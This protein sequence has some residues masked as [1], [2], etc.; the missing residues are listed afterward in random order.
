M[1]SRDSRESKKS[2]EELKMDS[3]TYKEL[4]AKIL[5]YKKMGM[6]T[7]ILEIALDEKAEN[8]EALFRD[9][10][11]KAEEI[12]GLKVRLFHLRND[13]NE[14]M[15]SAI[16]SKMS[17]IDNY[18]HILESVSRLEETLDPDNPEN[19]RSKLIVK[20]SSLSDTGYDVTG[21][22]ALKEGD[23][24]EFALAVHAFEDGIAEME[25]LRKRLDALT[26][27]S[28]REDIVGIL[29]LMRDPTKV[30]EINKRISSIEDLVNHGEEFFSKKIETLKNKGYDVTAFDGFVFTDFDLAYDKIRGFEKKVERYEE[31]RES[32]K[33]INCSSLAPVIEELVRKLDSFENLP[34]IEK[35]FGQ[36]EG[37]IKSRR[38]PL[39]E[40]LGAFKGEGFDISELMA[41]HILNFDGFSDS[42]EAFEK[43][44][45]EM[46]TVVTEFK[47]IDNKWF[48]KE[49]SAISG[50]MRNPFKTAESRQAIEDLRLA[51]DARVRE[52]HGEA[53]NWKAQGLDVSYLEEAEGL[54]LKDA[55]EVYETAKEDIKLLEEARFRLA[56]LDRGTF[57]K[58]IRELEESLSQPRNVH[59]AF[60]R[61]EEL[62]GSLQKKREDITSKV[63]E[64]KGRGYSVARMEPLLEKRID[65]L[66]QEWNR[67]E[68]DVESLMTIERGLADLDTP[69]LA[70]KV[71]EVRFHLK[72]PDKRTEAE[73]AFAVLEEA[74]AAVRDRL[75]SR[76][77][78][79]TRRG[80]VTLPLQ[81]ILKGDLTELSTAVENFEKLIEKT[82]PLKEKLD[83]LD[84]SLFT[85]RSDEIREKLSDP[86]KIEEAR[87]G[88]KILEDEIREEKKKIKNQI[89]ELS[90]SG[91][92]V[93]PLL[94]ETSSSLKNQRKL[95]EHFVSCIDRVRGLKAY[96][97]ELD[98]EVFP[99]E[100]VEIEALLVH[101]LRHE[102]AEMMIKELEKKVT[103][104]RADI[105]AQVSALAEKGYEV[106][107]ILP[108]LGARLALLQNRWDTFS[109]DITRLKK[110][111]GEL[112][113]LDC[114]IFQTEARQII[115][116]LKI[117]GRENKA[118][119]KIEVLRERIRAAKNKYA[120]MAAN[121]E[122]LG[123]S[124]RYLR[125]NM[126]RPLVKVAEI[127]EDFEERIE[128]ITLLE[129]EYRRLDRESFPDLC[130]RI[131][132]N[133]KDPMALERVDRDIEALKGRIAG[134]ASQFAEFVGALRE[135]GFEVSYLEGFL[136]KRISLQ[137]AAAGRFE[138]WKADL[139]E[140][141]TL[142][143]DLDS[144]LDYDEICRLMEMTLDVTKIEAVRERVENYRE[145]LSTE[146]NN[147]KERAMELW[148]S[149]FDISALTSAYSKP[150]AD[151]D[152]ILKTFEEE[153]VKLEPLVEK[154]NSLDCS[155]HLSDRKDISER[156]RKLESPESI[157]TLLEGL[158][159]KIE[160][161]RDDLRR[162]IARLQK[163][164]FDISF[165]KPVWSLPLDKAGD[166][167]QK[168]EDMASRA[169]KHIKDLE[170]LD[171]SL[172]PEDTQAILR[173]LKAP[174]LVFEAEEKIESVS[175]GVKEFM[176]VAA[177]RVAGIAKS[178]F[179]VDELKPLEGENC[180]DIGSRL[181]NAETRVAE[182][183]EIASRMEPLRC[184]ALTQDF[185]KFDALFWNPSK[186][187][188]TRKAAARIE[189]KHS[190]ASARWEAEV[191]KLEADG[192]CVSSLKGSADADLDT[193]LAVL[194]AY[195]MNA[196][197]CSELSRLLER[198]DTSVLPGAADQLKKMLKNPDNLKD[199]TRDFE[200]MKAEL[201]RLSKK[202]EGDIV[203]LES[204]GYDTESLVDRI[205]GIKLKETID[206]IEEVKGS[207]PA[208]ESMRRELL[209]MD[210]GPF[211]MEM[212]NIILRIDSLG[213]PSEI[214]EE[215]DKLKGL[216]E[217]KAQGFE[218]FIARQDKAGFDT[219][220]LAAARK[221]SLKRKADL[222]FDFEMT[223]PKARSL[224]ERLEL[225]DTSTLT[226]EAERIRKILKNPFNAEAASARLDLLESDISEA[227][228]KLRK[229]VDDLG[230]EGFMAG[231]IFES[232]PS[233]A[234][235]GAEVEKA[236]SEIGKAR[237]LILEM[238]GIDFSLFRAD[239]AEIRDLLTDPRKVQ[240][241]E[242][243]LQGVK[244]KIELKAQE[245]RKKCE[246]FITRG[247]ECQSLVA[248]LEK[249]P[250]S[251]MDA[252]IRAFEESLARIEALAVKLKTLDCSLNGRELEDLGRLLRNPAAYPQALETVEK[253]ETHIMAMRSNLSS[254]ISKAAAE[255]YAVDRT[256]AAL[257]KKNLRDATADMDIFQREMKELKALRDEFNALA[258][259]NLEGELKK[260]VALTWDPRNLP[261]IPGELKRVL[262]LADAM[263]ARLT[264]ERDGWSK[265]GLKTGSVDKAL[266]D[267]VP[268][269]ELERNF[270][271]FR[272]KVSR[273]DSL[274]EDL[275][276]TM[277]ISF[278]KDAMKVK[279]LL[280]D[281]DKWEDADKA[282]QGLKAKIK[283]TRHKALNEIT[284]F[285]SRGYFFDYLLEC[286]S[287]E[288][289]EI[290]S[291][292]SRAR[293]EIAH[294]EE[295][296]SKI[297][298]TIVH[299]SKSE[300]RELTKLFRNKGKIGEAL[301]K[302]DSLRNSIASRRE[303]VIKEIGY[304][305]TLGYQIPEPDEETI[306]APLRLES[307]ASGVRASIREIEILKQEL[308]GIGTDLAPETENRIIEMMKDIS[309]VEKVREEI[310]NCR[311]AIESER[312]SLKAELEAF[313][314]KGYDTSMIALDHR[315]TLSSHREAMELFRAKVAELES[316]GE[317]LDKIDAPGFDTI[318]D[319]IRNQLCDIRLIGQAKTS[320][321][322]LNSQIENEK[323][324][325]FA[326]A[327]DLEVRGYD[328]SPLNAVRS[329][330][331][332]KILSSFAD[333]RQSVARL[334]ALRKTLES[335]DEGVLEN[336]FTRLM[337]MT[338]KVTNI[339][340][341]ETGISILSGKLGELRTQARSRCQVFEKVG[342]DVARLTDVLGRN[343]GQFEKSF[344]DYSKRVIEADSLKRELEGKDAELFPDKKAS[345]LRIC[346]DPYAIPRARE[347]LG[348][349]DRAIND[350]RREVAD[351]IDGFRSKGYAIP[352][353]L[354]IVYDE[355]VPLSKV[356]SVH[357]DFVGMTEKLKN[358]YS[359]LEKLD[360]SLFM[361]EV[362]ELAQGFLDFAQIPKI[363]AKIEDLKSRIATRR[364]DLL[365]EVEYYR[366][367]GYRC[368]RF[369]A[370]E[371]MSLSDLVET[372]EFLKARLTPVKEK[373][374]RLSLYLRYEKEKQ[375]A[376]ALLDRLY[377]VD[378]IDTTLLEIDS[379]EKR[380]KG[381][382]IEAIENYRASGLPTGRLEASME[383]EPESIAKVFDDFEADVK[384]LE[385]ARD[386]LSSIDLSKYREE[387]TIIEGLLDN[388][389][390]ATKVR[391]L[392]G[393]IR[394]AEEDRRT[395]T[396]AILEEY[397]NSGY[398]LSSLGDIE[399]MGISELEESV[400]DIGKKIDELS[401]IAAEAQRVRSWQLPI[402]IDDISTFLKDPA[403]VDKARA[404]VDAACS[405]AAAWIVERLAGHR[406]A[407]FNVKFVERLVDG[408]LKT[409]VEAFRMFSTDILTL[410]GLEKELL[411]FQ[412]FKSR[413]EYILAAAELKNPAA[414]DFIREKIDALKEARSALEAEKTKQK[415]QEIE[416]KAQEAKA[417]AEKAAAE[418]AARKAEEEEAAKK[419]AG[420]QAVAVAAAA[421]PVEG[422]AS[423]KPE[424]AAAAP[425]AGEAAAP[426]EAPKK[427]LP[428]K[429]P[430]M[431]DE[432]KRKFE[433]WK[434]RERGD[435]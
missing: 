266:S 82:R 387:A 291:R 257:L 359:S 276:R 161:D 22:E 99:A 236:V 432:M 2:L 144:S 228:S 399:G 244:K 129:S 130:S 141:K 316:I 3:N 375:E 150:L 201:A 422:K 350:K 226:D 191:A 435:S 239:E 427:P 232:K 235:A 247:Y 346:K 101:P 134:E 297:S 180:A 286:P 148:E 289:E 105:E 255:G 364:T 290:L 71:E 87:E 417:A 245:F 431:T 162:R 259:G 426:A 95:M 339:S 214:K 230:R 157:T 342:Y 149:G 430:A 59:D 332:T 338:W 142:I 340:E 324:N 293:K 70:G 433:E 143:F 215:I 122:A 265:R 380:A 274:R 275:T 135:E 365:K 343:L 279:I 194:T 17:S 165:T 410:A 196:A 329:L 97:S 52:Y 217:T 238:S 317:T 30:G 348:E 147:R 355:S 118:Q 29:A 13:S 327:M 107:E 309:L 205:A 115:G 225:M 198:T 212:K 193:K 174:E 65:L 159:R 311:R 381:H 187:E 305:R 189:K 46:R 233:L 397:R 169:A 40:K 292:V 54:P 25:S 323:T 91:Y 173:L 32:A 171:T 202:I 199:C 356:V 9:F 96:M 109:E 363:E 175:N 67:F 310:S 301:S 113:R 7:R 102:R 45:S 19:I 296:A 123:Y 271:L 220:E 206:L 92:S 154:L 222:M 62:Q 263:R 77:K 396:L 347:A 158:E 106:S 176:A 136:D 253:L 183:K 249:L 151:F 362:A 227:W 392:V 278:A 181:E 20:V 283:T 240:P 133:L 318:K 160:A 15:V 314:E 379:F 273:I 254:G 319:A 36:I 221:A 420:A 64:L 128:K 416:R 126:D 403:Q 48:P 108:F 73:N 391:R 386:M 306:L 21:L 18:D 53:I 203:F 98:S 270:E 38:K 163:K 204:Q 388:P 424:G 408:T 300:G 195:S 304:L 88:I 76:I 264:A 12:V 168:F 42:V 74:A 395:A 349:L 6:D 138:S 218:A 303:S 358:L 277:T 110:V 360:T 400:S 322:Q 49:I 376:Q 328:I 197:E 407:G 117:P 331:L 81:K 26:F 352:D 16:E 383:L 111:E 393:A 268:M 354:D 307:F 78:D 50:L 335:M 72:D 282:L 308:H 124:A 241:A 281:P 44:V 146:W 93:E 213:N 361:D 312:N 153:S 177:A 418:E 372:L 389:S 404:A 385:E 370:S 216:S 326:E 200:V 145:K 84:C 272:E 390:S 421:K 164:G 11:R 374:K 260:A 294:F 190:S 402:E 103:S 334:E 186:I 27:R 37:S 224:I 251:L 114:S 210:L 269:A 10:S 33:I 366:G 246:I 156:I 287:L 34:Q 1:I 209:T 172:H 336:E 298:E 182:L 188:E 152:R 288:V 69:I 351:S 89:E 369:E 261:K 63:A 401:E 132:E 56:T 100:T 208:I 57:E 321:A 184:S 140:L 179:I 242:K 250:Q 406:E 325:I 5:D 344:T 367:Q 8:T 127:F 104:R 405:D 237:K 121:F 425:S 414:C 167:I 382:F 256:S 4:N 139:N 243:A 79:F 90:K 415:L 211:E 68:E 58:E 35:E 345:I 185:S 398:S 47:A 229:V 409:L 60:R 295:E 258:C 330:G 428:P 86:Q 223:L 313:A 413:P 192:W 85:E 285:E 155:L 248:A 24:V 43:A 423:A 166:L 116:E 178:G 302:L 280:E 337:E 55:I 83:S 267:R 394:K 41:M 170:K 299:L 231:Y 384:V 75:G 333:F 234:R 353:G 252:E 14:F 112:H 120:S 39:I 61:M 378:D 66:V 207:I 377:V 368:A 320:I 23:I 411:A 412:E 125:E 137:R 51:M 219:S 434:K 419:A 341:V 80:F 315:E 31:L 371:S 28:L 262:A 119:A 429:A 357:S 94:K 131:E 373:R 284:A